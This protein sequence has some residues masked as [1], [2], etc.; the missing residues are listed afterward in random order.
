[1]ILGWYGTNI[2]QSELGG[3]MRPYQIANGD[4]DDKAIFTDEFVAWAKAYGYEAIASPNGDIK[5][6]KEF[7]SKGIPVVVKTMLFPY[8]D[9]G[10]FRIVKGY[11]E[12]KQVIIQDDSYQGPNREIAYY[13]FL[14]LWQPFHYVYIV[15]YKPE[16]A[17]TIEA[18]I[19][20]EMDEQIAWQNV[21]MRSK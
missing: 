6:L 14:A 11:D 2:S 1:M 7:T 9:V 21:L 16:Q 12:A 5:T 3:K 17:E 4:N 18:I 20:S 10:H 19:G 13:D 8:D 15:V